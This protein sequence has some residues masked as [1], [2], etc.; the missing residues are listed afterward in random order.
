MPA[1]FHAIQIQG[2]S[3]VSARQRVFALVQNRPAPLTLGALLVLLSPRLHMRC[4]LMIL[5]VLLADRP[6]YRAQDKLFPGPSLP[7]LQ[8]TVRAKH[9]STLL[10]GSQY[11][12]VNQGCGFRY[13][14]WIECMQDI[15]DQWQNYR[16]GT[17]S[18]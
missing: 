3:I 13:H 7:G 9:A 2:S 10:L 11:W 16:T 1:S 8:Q 15:L 18:C 6:G 4:Q 12:L 17:I 14:I 5:L